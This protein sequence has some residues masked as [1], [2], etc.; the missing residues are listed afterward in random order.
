MKT[1]LRCT[2]AAAFLALA[3]CAAYPPEPG[4]AT[5]YYAAPAY[6][7]VYAYPDIGFGWG[8]GWGYWHHGWDHPQGGNPHVAWHQPGGWSHPGSWSH[9]GPG[10]V[11][12]GAVA[13]GGGH[14]SGRP[15]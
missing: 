7:E 15:G 5:G 9:P 8:G 10:A 2:T 4:Y 14:A 6:G 12:G 1:I 13:H 11:H 3:G